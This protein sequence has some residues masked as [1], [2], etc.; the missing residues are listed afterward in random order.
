MFLE[1]LAEINEE[2]VRVMFLKGIIQPSQ[3]T[4]SELQKMM[5]IISRLEEA[6]KSCKAL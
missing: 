5:M 1:T 3:L 4:K 6:K 2:A